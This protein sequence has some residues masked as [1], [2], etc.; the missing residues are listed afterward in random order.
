MDA[1]NACKRNDLRCLYCSYPTRSYAKC[2]INQ[3][4]DNPLVY[5][6]LLSC[7]NNNNNNFG[8]NNNNNNNNFGFGTYYNLYFR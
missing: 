5:Q 7:N 6:S 8:G 3:F 4:I 2:L 1:I